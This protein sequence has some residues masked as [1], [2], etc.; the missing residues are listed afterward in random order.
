MAKRRIPDGRDYF[1]VGLAEYAAA[2]LE[3]FARRFRRDDR[4]PHAIPP[5]TDVTDGE[6]AELA[7][8]VNDD[9]W[10][11]RCDD[12]GDAQ[13]VWFEEP[14]FMCAGC[15]NR[16]YGYSWRRV[17]LPAG[18]TAS[19]VEA[20]LRLRPRTED[21]NWDPRTETV[22]TL[23]EQNREKGDPVPEGDD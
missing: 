21:R 9:R 20:V 10:L 16:R 19:R 15:F 11:V 5:R 13:F 7:A 17:V 6:A 8:F 23:K 3:G 12:C 4:E 2:V 22:A 18:S 14:L 1:G